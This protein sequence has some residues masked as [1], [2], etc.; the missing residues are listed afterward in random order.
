V[1]YH[2]NYNAGH[3]FIRPLTV[4]LEEVEWK[5]QTVPRFKKVS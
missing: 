2:A 1:I 5:G 4:W 3:T